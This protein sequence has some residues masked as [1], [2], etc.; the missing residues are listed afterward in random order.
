MPASDMV[1]MLGPLKAFI[2]TFLF[3]YWIITCH[4]RE[5]H[6]LQLLPTDTEALFLGTQ[7]TGMLVEFRLCQLMSRFCRII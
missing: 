5:H 6:S 2:P 7:N 4:R 1:A 3:Y